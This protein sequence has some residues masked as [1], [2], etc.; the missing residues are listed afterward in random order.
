[1]DKRIIVTILGF[2]VL[3][4]GFQL[5]FNP[6]LKYYVLGASSGL[7]ISTWIPED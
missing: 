6:D 2:V 3:F 5:G 4:I 7:F 1:M